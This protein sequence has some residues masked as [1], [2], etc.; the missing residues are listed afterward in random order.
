MVG[1]WWSPYTT[2]IDSFHCSLLFFLAIEGTQLSSYNH[3]LQSH[4]QLWF[5]SFFYIP[6]DKRPGSS[7]Y[8]I[9]NL[10]P[11]LW[12]HPMEGPIIANESRS[13]T[14]HWWM[15]GPTIDAS[16]HES[17]SWKITNWSRQLQYIRGPQEWMRSGPKQPMAVII[18]SCD[19]DIST[20][21]IS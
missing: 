21:W 5:I 2:H 13:M 15:M 16:F 8:V 18:Q 1:W 20:L 11:F 10:W 12:L 17:G 4:F 9:R 19:H 7:W 6:T 14:S 3:D